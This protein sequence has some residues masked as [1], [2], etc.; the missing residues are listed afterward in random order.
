[1]SQI[2]WKYYLPDEIPTNMLHEILT[3]LTRRDVADSAPALYLNRIGTNGKQGETRKDIADLVR[4]PQTVCAR[5]GLL[6][7]FKNR[8]KYLEQ[9]T[10]AYSLPKSHRGQRENGRNEERHRRS[11]SQSANRLC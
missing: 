1:M 10:C 2:I 5:N 6:N 9:M 8:N 3:I 11:R 7:C 4:N